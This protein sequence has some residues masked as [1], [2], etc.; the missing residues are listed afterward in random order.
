MSRIRALSIHPVYPVN[1]VWLWSLLALFCAGMVSAAGLRAQELP[2]L[3]DDMLA[4]TE[5]ALHV[6]VQTGRVAGVTR[7][8]P[9]AEIGA[10]IVDV[11]YGDYQA[12]EWLG[13]AKRVEGDYVK[14]AVSA[15]L[16]LLAREGGGVLLDED[17]SPSRRDA[18]AARIGEYRRRTELLTA[19]K[20][21]PDYLLRSASSALLRVEIRKTAPYDRGGG[22]LS[23]THTAMVRAALQGDFK[24]G[25]TV[26][27]IEE[28]RR[29]LRFEPLA[30]PDRIVLLSYSRSV[31]DGQMYW[32]LHERVN[33]G[34]TEAGLATV[35][36]DLARVRAAQ[37]E[38][39]GK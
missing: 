12:G 15:R 32:W 5:A 3:A 11:L 2:A 22:N 13:Y 26:E 35:K 34:Y 1:P 6:D 18:L 7:T 14:P 31:R 23:A 17:F 10:K 36:A 4:R 19:D 28:S 16:V 20:H 21:V 24:P 25:D 29:K 27:F 30:S 9:V 37:A 8:G 38:K 39:A 33:Y